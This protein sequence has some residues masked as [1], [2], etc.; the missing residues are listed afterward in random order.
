MQWNFTIP[1]ATPPGLYIMRLESIYPRAKFNTTQFFASCMHVQINGPGG[2]KTEPGPTV[3]FPGAF[4]E[5][6]PGKSI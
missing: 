3:R 6:H 4:D 1:D 2:A 5:Y